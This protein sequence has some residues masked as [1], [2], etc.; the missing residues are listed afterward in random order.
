[1][2]RSTQ[3]VILSAVLILLL[4]E[5]AYTGDRFIVLASTTSTVNSGLFDN[6]LPAFTDKTGISVRVVGVGTGQAIKVAER[7]D[8]DVLLV[9]HKI[10]ELIFVER[11]F[12]I[13][14]YDVM[15]NDFVVVGPKLDPAGIQS[16]KSVV[17]AYQKIAATNSMFLSRG[18]DSGT[19]K[20]SLELWGQASV[21]V[22]SASGK[23][24][25]E[26]GSGMGATLN[27]AMSVNGYTLTDRATWEAFKNKGSLKL[28]FEGGPS[29]RNQYG[30][31]MVN[32]SLHKHVKANLASE[33]IGWLI[34]EDGQ[35]V[36]NGFRL[37]GNQM[38]FANANAR[39]NTNLER[40]SFKLGTRQ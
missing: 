35:A 17:A 7:G 12:G 26:S 5:P 9:H 34:S 2:L 30:I 39:G 40:N 14:R 31:I 3:S 15:Y 13:K 10:S 20:R 16:V 33:F 6:I 27:I 28:L 29:L 32:P 24:Y 18:D 11:G 36:I 1:M 22:I 8:A 19:H 38:F 21:D 23:W 25:R 37:N 4:R